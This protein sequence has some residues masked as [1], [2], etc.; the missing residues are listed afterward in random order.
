MFCVDGWL[1]FPS[2]VTIF[3]EMCLPFLKVSLGFWAKQKPNETVRKGFITL[4]DLLNVIMFNIHVN[5]AI[6]DR[7]FSFLILH[8]GFYL[9]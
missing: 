2:W 5:P 4:T 9:D 8:F 6:S 1:V 7:V 3:D